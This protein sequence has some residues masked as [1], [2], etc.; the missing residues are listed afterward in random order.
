MIDLPVIPVVLFAYARPEHLA[1]VLACL[2]ENHVPLIYAYCDGAKGGSDGAAVVAVRGMLRNIDWSEVRLTERNKNLGLGRNVLAG[3]TEVAAQHEAFIVWE[4]D[5]ICVPGTYAWVCAALRRYAGDGRVMSVSAWTH[6]Q[7]VPSGVDGEPYFDG[8]A[9]CWVWG[10]YARSWRGMEQTAREK[11]AAVAAKGIAPD[12]YGTDLPRMARAEARKN[13]WAVRWLYHHLQQGGLC[14]RPPWSMVEHIGFD[15]TATNAKTMPAWGGRQLMAAPAL[16][17]CWPDPREHPDCAALWRAMN[18][19]VGLGRRLWH[20]LQ[21]IG[22]AAKPLKKFVPAP[23]R[24]WLLVKLGWRWFR[25]EYPDWR[26]ASRQAGGYAAGII[27][28]KVLAAS[29]AVSRGEAAYEQDGV[30]FAEARPDRP[31]IDALQK[32]RDDC[33]GR[34]RVIDFGGALG[35]TYWRHRDWLCRIPALR[36]DVVEQAQFVEAGRKHF[37]HAPL[38][39]FNTVAEAEASSPHE[40]LLCSTTLQYLE[41]PFAILREWQEAGWTYLLFNNLPLHESGPDTVRV[42]H[43]PPHIYPASYPV[44]F[45]NR[46]KFVASLSDRYELVRQFSSEAVW[47]VDRRD[48]PSRGL[49]FRRRPSS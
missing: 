16:P 8:R 17:P 27:L 32:V 44:W 10:G 41:D 26:E 31:L 18:P 45:F 29:L 3:V 28:E 9:E 33:G 36:W 4:D 40:L 14:L 37:D 7:I 49:L 5:L 13:I 2:R 1:R 23:L 39:F 47:P 11:M 15:A 42:Q 21:R 19:S 35:S 24:R 30:L 20:R 22:G 38:R 12:T 6:P 43:V 25:G 34:L 48:Y 46:E